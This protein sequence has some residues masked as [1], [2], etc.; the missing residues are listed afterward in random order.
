[1]QIHV[2]VVAKCNEIKMMQLVIC[3]YNYSETKSLTGSITAKSFR[4]RFKYSKTQTYW[5]KYGDI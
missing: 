4:Y 5:L 3:R 2:Q 1:M